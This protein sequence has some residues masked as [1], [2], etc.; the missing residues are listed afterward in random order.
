MAR[1][2]RRKGSERGYQLG[3][4]NFTKFTPMDQLFVRIR[5]IRVFTASFPRRVFEKRDL[6]AEDPRL[7]RA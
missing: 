1:L 7:D 3:D 5:V 6:R 2:S 4:T